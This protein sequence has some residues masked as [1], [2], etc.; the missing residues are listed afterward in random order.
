MF[1]YS[2]TCEQRSP[3][4]E[5]DYGL[6]RQVVFIWRFL[7]L[8]KRYLDCLTKRY[9]DCLTKRYLDWGIYLQDYLYLE[10]VFNT[11]LTVFLDSGSS[12]NLP[13]ISIKS[14][15]R[16]SKW[17]LRFEPAEL[18]RLLT[19]SS[20]SHCKIKRLRLMR[21]EPLILEPTFERI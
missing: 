12:N 8:T 16:F 3:K 10:V 20:W 5:T 18:G 19:R 15:N 6:Y 11:G 14:T 2:Q 9:L 7:C 21:H 1:L 13:L 4:G 17:K